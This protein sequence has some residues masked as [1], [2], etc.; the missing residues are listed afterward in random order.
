MLPMP[1]VKC[2][3]PKECQRPNAKEPMPFRHWSFGLLSAFRHLEFGIGSFR[4]KKHGGTPRGTPYPEVTGLICRVPSRAFS[5]APENTL[6]AYLCRFWYGFRYGF[7]GRHFVDIGILN[8]LRQ[9]NQPAP[10]VDGV[11]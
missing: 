1:N 11:P 9:S 2:R 10:L 5:R 3:M 6:L 4:N 7:L 8:A